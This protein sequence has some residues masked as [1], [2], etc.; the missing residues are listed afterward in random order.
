MRTKKTFRNVIIS[1][2]NNILNIIVSLFVQK[3]FL[4]TLG[5]SYL[6]LNGIFSNVLSILAVAELG[7]GTAII[8]KMYKPIDEKD[9]ESISKLMNFYKRC[10]TII[11]AVMTL[12][13]LLIIPF[14][15]TILGDISQIKENVYLLYLIFSLDII[16]SYMLAYKKSILFADQKEYISTLIHIGYL[17]IMNS[18]QIAFLIHTK[19]YIIFLIIKLSCRIIENIVVNYIV[20]KKY[21]FLRKYK[22]VKLNTDDK[23]DIIQKVRSLFVHKLAGFVVTGTDTILISYLLGGLVTVGYYSNYTLIIA[24]VTTVFNQVFISMTSSIGNL[25]V[26]EDKNRKL[27]VFNKIQFLNFWIFTFASICIFCIIESFITVWIGD[28]YILSKFVLISL[29]LNFFMQGMRR[30]MMSFKEAAGI[31]YEDRFIP[32]IESIINL[33]A[34]II[35]LKIFGLPGVALG[36]ITSTLIV[37]LYSYPKYVYKSIFEKS[38]FYYIRDIAIYLVIACISLL[39]TYEITNLFTVSNMYFKIIVNALICIF[40][41]NLIIYI[42]FR[43]NEY[44]QYYI[45]LIKNTLRKIIKRNKTIC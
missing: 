13:I 20:N 22:N 25:L 12:I 5:E 36:T 24:S 8:Y 37:F 17:V 38:G 27:E 33:V 32:I 40:V 3:I 14:L 7:I 9:E 16:A 34:S 41:P 26:K 18:L 10:Y 31:F 42:I 30:T 21:N 35:F 43:K 2:I 6:G 23:K 39:V 28:K 45:D 1:V 4:N 19:N 44:Y 11:I 29:V 15:K